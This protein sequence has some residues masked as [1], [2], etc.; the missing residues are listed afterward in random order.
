MNHIYNKNRIKENC[1]WQGELKVLLGK[2][3][4]RFCVVFSLII[5]I[6]LWAGIP[7]A[8][9]TEKPLQ[10]VSNGK[11]SPD[12][13][14]DV[15]ENKVAEVKERIKASEAAENEHAAQQFGVS[16]FDMQARTTKLREILA[17]HQRLLTSFKR[18][19]TLDKEESLLS[20][21]AKTQ[22]QIEL[23][24]RPP[25]SLGF[26][27]QILDQIAAASQEKETVQ[28]EKSFAEKALQDARSRREEAEKTMRGL[29]DQL[30]RTEALKNGT[31]PKWDF[32]QGKLN[33]EL[34]QTALD[35]LKTRL[36]NLQTQIRL[37]ELK[38]DIARQSITW[39][40]AHL[41]F[42]EADL[43]KRLQDFERERAELQERQGRLMREQRQVEEAWLLAQKRE[44]NAKNETERAIAAAFLKAREAWRETCQRVLEQ[45]E[46][47]VHLLNQREQ[48][49]KRRY[50]LIKAEVGNE[51]LEA[52]LKEVQTQIYG[53]D[54]I[55]AL[56]QTYDISLQSQITALEKQASEKAVHVEIKQ[57]LQEQIQALRKLAERRVEYLALLLVT[58]RVN[59]RLFDEITA[60]AGESIAFWK[61]LTA[62]SGK[63][64][65]VW[66]F[67]LWVIDD[68]AVTV[69]KVVVALFIFVF[70]LFMLKY[71]S[72][73]I[74]GRL[75]PRMRLEAS[76][77]AA[78]EKMIHYLAFLLVVLF[79]L[80][81]VNIPLTAFTFLGGA[82]AIGVGFGAQNL[83]NNFISGF[84]I[85]AERP[86]RIGD[87]I[88]MEQSFAIVEEIGARCTRIRTPAN[89][90][91]LV[92]NSHFLER[93]ITNWTLSDQLIRSNVT[94]GVVY[95]SPVRDVER[96]LIKAAHEHKRT[97]ER[98]E[99]FV[100]FN[101]FGDN[102]LV[103]DVY[104]WI[105]MTHMMD[106]KQIE[107][108]I[109]FRINELFRE[110]GIVIAFPQRDV[111]IDST[112]PLEFKILHAERS[113]G[114]AKEDEKT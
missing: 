84:I 86:I 49:W 109:R 85:M 87:L 54:R 42:D 27:D 24:E 22:Q 111:H 72:R 7:P 6:A 82:I 79:S 19:A 36:E 112:R 89:I 40:R 44:P 45:T 55:L 4:A 95:G 104:F 20:D 99:P 35:F 17:T 58:Q 38:T 43:Q 88:E 91:V 77:A 70:G 15:L 28:S 64:K 83:I 51:Q 81:I 74:R 11:D 39:V 59:Q 31:K 50:E 60:A 66:N 107:S 37:A 14:S 62:V 10:K 1:P 9:A 30:E 26:Y 105:S 57:H 13:S 48:A 63:A 2:G 68:Q 76:A 71:L 34:A 114:P 106:R 12:I 108:D 113:E 73:V 69:R 78:L 32:E 21:K 29:R 41:H 46:H 25:Y 5:V 75:L 52:W 18:R 101:D 16:L 102:S 53:I 23:S 94:V 100:F 8:H 56:H 61:T 103:F 67:E 33:L 98:P 65:N 47:M 80:H 3:W 96:L 97:L 93:H 110:A 90:R 92:P